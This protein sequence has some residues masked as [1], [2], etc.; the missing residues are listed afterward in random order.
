MVF[1]SYLFYLKGKK[2]SLQGQLQS[3]QLQG[4][5]NCITITVKAIV[6]TVRATQE[7]GTGTFMYSIISCYLG[8]I[9]L[10]D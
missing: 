8:G 2:D 6:N 10:S 1:F 3:Q 4:Q 5:V 9:K 7:I